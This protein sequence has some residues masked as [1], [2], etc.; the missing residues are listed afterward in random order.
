MFNKFVSSQVKKKDRSQNYFLTVKP[1][2]PFKVGIKVTLER[3]KRDTFADLTGPVS[4]L[5]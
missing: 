4:Y 5:G 3:N 1:L 2:C